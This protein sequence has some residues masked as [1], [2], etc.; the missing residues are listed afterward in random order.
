MI[1]SW[2][3]NAWRLV[4]L[5]TTFQLLAIQG[6]TQFSGNNLLEIQYGKIPSDTVNSFATLY[7]RTVADYRWK[8]FKGGITLE[9]FYSPY[10]GRSYF[11]VQQVRAQYQNKGLEINLGS[12]Y[13]TLGR[14]TLL[15]SYQIQGAILEDVT[16][17]SRNYFQRDIV[18]ANVRYR[19]KKFSAKALYG[20]PLNN[21]FPPNQDLE[22]RRPDRIGALY[23]DYQLGTQTLGMALMHLDNESANSVF[24][25]LTAS[26]N[27]GSKL[28]Y[29]TEFSKNVSDY[30][31]SD[32]SSDAAYAFYFNSDISFETVGISAEFKYYSNFALGAGFNEP[33][34]LIREHTYR[35]LNRST[36]VLQPFNESG[37]QIEMYVQFPN[38][39]TLTMNNSIAINDFGSSFVFQEYFA[40]YDMLINKKHHFRIFGDFAQDPFKGEMDRVT[41]GAYGD[42]R[43]GKLT[44]LK[45]EIEMQTFEREGVQ[46]YNVLALLGFNYTS[47]VSVSILAEVSNDPFITEE[48]QKVWFGGN[49]KYKLNDK[50]TILLFGGERRGGPACNSGV[51]YEVLDFSGVELRLTSRF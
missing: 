35:L 47:K 46:V 37:Y 28:S 14:G 48:D 27:I 17:R 41:L 24:S 12:F 40:E 32:F 22:N 13:E 15:R 25:M 2:A 34:A 30:S 18:G 16:Y 4:L 9:Q 20:S 51:C 39:S 42:W 26:G 44:G 5:I 49:L 36:H 10:E 23:T 43:T 29:F 45:S 8:Q 31:V 50:N 33:P 21:V 19:L 7:D 3:S 38:Q 6:Y 1:S 11:K